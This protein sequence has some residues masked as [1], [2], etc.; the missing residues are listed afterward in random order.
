VADEEWLPFAPKSFDAVVRCVDF[1]TYR[2]PFPKLAG[3]G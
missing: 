1:D 2:G 3:V